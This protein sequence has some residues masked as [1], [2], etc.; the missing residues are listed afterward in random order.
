MKCKKLFLNVFILI[1]ISGNCAF[2]ADS[3]RDTFIQCAKAYMGVPYRDGGSSRSGM[4]CSG[5]VYVAA[6]DAGISLPRTAAEMYKISTRISDSER[7]AGDLVF[8]AVG[9]S[10]SHVGIYLGN[11]QMLNSASDGPR[12]GVII[13]KLSEPYWQ[14]HYY[15]AGRIINDS[16]A[17]TSQKPDTP[18]TTNTPSTTTSSSGSKSSNAKSMK[19][20]RNAS[21][22][23]NFNS[24]L[25]WS[26]YTPSNQFGFWPKGGTLQTEFQLNLWSI[27]PGIMVRY[28][29]PIQSYTNFEI[30]SLF[31]TFNLPICLT[32]HLNDYISFYTGVVLSTGT[33]ASQPQTLF[34]T[35]KMVQAPIFPGIFGV[36]FQTPKVRLGSVY[37]SLVQ[38]ISYTHYKA[39]EGYDKMTFKESLAQ[40]INFSTGISITLPF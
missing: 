26:F 23:F 15:C 12:T 39:A 21:V 11:N 25:D 29:Y 6:R 17:S 8:F 34:G 16:V 33:V 31:N 20:Y 32:L 40:G 18:T 36:S 22:Y 13:S 3:L 4:D 35:D 24:Y 30:G 7:K 19:R 37:G 28:T 9:S 14:S 2:A 1:L 27:N 5:F 38:D 10:I